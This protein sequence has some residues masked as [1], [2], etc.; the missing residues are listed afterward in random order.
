MN[1]PF[2]ES[3]AEQAALD[4]LQGAGWQV[5]NGAESVPGEP[6]AERD[7]HGQIVLAQRRSDALVRLNPA[8]PAE[9]LDDAFRKL[10]RP[11]G[12]DPIASNR[13]LHC[14]ACSATASRLAREP[15][16]RCSRCRRC[17]PDCRAW[18]IPA[19]QHEPANSRCMPASTSRPVIAPS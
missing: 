7:D 18:T 13:A 3:V 4:W 19:A 1:H 11:E 16:R 17:L 2:T 9:A 5:R 8:P 15:G 14:T 6:A 10:A 12:A